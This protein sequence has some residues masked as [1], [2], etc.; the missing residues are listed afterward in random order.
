MLK[1]GYWQGLERESKLPNWR[2]FIDS[3][4]HPELN[5][6]YFLLHTRP[7]K[8]R[9]DL[10]YRSKVAV[11]Y[12]HSRALVVPVFKS[13][14]E[15]RTFR[16]QTPSLFF[17]MYFFWISTGTKCLLMGTFLTV[18][19][20]CALLQGLIK[21]LEVTVMIVVLPEWNTFELNRNA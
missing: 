4:L 1:R 9:P 14:I 8:I 16:Y 5:V 6:E 11:L 3:L 2:L 10:I 15:G 20:S 19:V 7:W 18:R 21:H 13:R 17:F 12:H